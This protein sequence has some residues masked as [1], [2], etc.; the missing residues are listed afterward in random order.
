MIQFLKNREIFIFTK[1]T[2]I[3]ST[4]IFPPSLSHINPNMNHLKSHTVPEHFQTL[5][6]ITKPQTLLHTTKP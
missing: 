6:H 1:N 5:P 3:I 2:K 4:Y